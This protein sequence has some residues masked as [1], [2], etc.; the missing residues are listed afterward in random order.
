MGLT[1]IEKCPKCGKVTEREWQI[2]GDSAPDEPIFY[3][4]CHNCGFEDYQ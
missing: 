1:I 3:K 4:V 2:D